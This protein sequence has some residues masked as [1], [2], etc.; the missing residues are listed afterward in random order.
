MSQLSST[1]YTL[2]ATKR[3]Q[4]CE[5]LKKYKYNFLCHFVTYIYK[6]LI[7]NILQGDIYR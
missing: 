3:T 4:T 5:T 1:T 6:V 2:Q 7:I